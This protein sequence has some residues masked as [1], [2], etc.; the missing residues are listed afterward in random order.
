MVGLHEH[1]FIDHGKL[2]LE[3]IGKFVSHDLQNAFFNW[4]P[5]EFELQIEVLTGMRP[6][7]KR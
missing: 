1:Q 4:R 5:P 2:L 3:S 7:K 6:E